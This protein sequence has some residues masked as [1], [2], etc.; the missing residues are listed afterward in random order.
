MKTCRMVSGAD[1]QVTMTVHAFKEQMN[2]SE[3]LN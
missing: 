1:I 2:M 3:K